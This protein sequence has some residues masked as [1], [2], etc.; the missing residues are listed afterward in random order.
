M[1]IPCKAEKAIVVKIDL[2]WL[3]FEISRKSGYDSNDEGSEDRVEGE[4]DH[5]EY[6]S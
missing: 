6:F 1:C 5:H 4:R 2:E 3:D